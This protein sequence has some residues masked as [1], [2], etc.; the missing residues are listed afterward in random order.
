M[1]SRKQSAE[2]GS[3]GVEIFTVDFF[4]PFDAARKALSIHTLQGVSKSRIVGEKHSESSRRNFDEIPKLRRNA[5]RGE[6]RAK[7]CN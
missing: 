7:E 3:I 4:T 5:A 2:G 1:R 6:Q